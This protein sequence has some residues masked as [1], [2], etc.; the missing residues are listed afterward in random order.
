MIPPQLRNEEYRFCK[1]T[2]YQKMP[3]EKGWTNG[4]TYNDPTFIEHIEKGGNYGVI[5][6]HGGL[7]ILDFDNLD[8]FTTLDP[9]LPYTFTTKSARKGYPHIYLRTQGVPESFK[10]LDS[11]GNSLIDIQGVGKQVVGPGSKLEN[12]RYYQVTN[13]AAIALFP[14]EKIVQ[15]IRDNFP[16]IHIKKKEERQKSNVP[17]DPKTVIIQ[18]HMTVEEVLKM[19]NI[20]TSRGNIQ[21]PLGHGSK[22]GQC[23]AYKGSIWKCF[24]CDLGGGITKLYRLLKHCTVEKAKEELIVKLIIEK[25]YEVKNGTN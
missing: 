12:G 7:Y 9:F 16:N 20:P 14:Y 13:L 17:L 8:A 3:Y 23:F 11:E 15:I 1:I 4:Y 6:G 24:H 10:V 18:E 25:R 5:G 21:C 22:A 2:P 19:F